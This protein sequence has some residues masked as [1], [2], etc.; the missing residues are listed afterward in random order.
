M[1]LSSVAE[2]MLWTGRYLQRA[3]SLARAVLAYE[4]LS[5][6]LPRHQDLGPLMRLVG[7]TEPSQMPSVA[8][9][10]SDVLGKLILDGENPSSVAG[11]LNRARDNL[12]RVR[13]S[14]PREVWTTVN[15][16][17]LKL[18]AT[19]TAHLAGV[20]GAA[21]DVVAAGSRIEG[22][23]T[24]SMTRDAAYSF[25][26]IGC[27]L[28]RA[29]MLLRIIDVVV[30]TMAPHGP[31]CLYDDVRW[32]G[33]LDAVAAHSMYRRHHPTKV[34]LP[35]VLAFLVDDA[36]FP[37]SLASCLGVVGDEVSSLP[38]SR[39]SCAA[40]AACVRASTALK[41]VSAAS[42][43]VQAALVLE[44]LAEFHMSLERSYFSQ[45]P[46]AEVFTRPLVQRVANGKPSA[47]FLSASA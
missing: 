19:E 2:S 31:E 35:T 21:E 25:L 12:R 27:H 41:G 37:R 18:A 20:L 14:V 38:N 32:R 6:D 30:S 33:L 10:P 47:A 9:E 42:L 46:E 44:R 5:L 1:L 7:C 28:E 11:A 22:D 43:P 8:T 36:A 40:Q 13:V 23:L 24:A 17:S 34:D 16:L 29:D 4:R 15:A 3:P 26:R 39:V 45:E